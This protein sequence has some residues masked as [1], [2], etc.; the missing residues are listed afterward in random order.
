MNSTHLIYKSPKI[1]IIYDKDND[2]RYVKANKHI[3]EGEIILIEHSIYSKDI[4][5][6]ESLVVNL[7]KYDN[8]L[9]DILYP[10]IRDPND[11]DED[12][13]KKKLELNIMGFKNPDGE[14]SINGKEWTA[15]NHNG[16]NPNVN[17]DCIIVNLP[18]LPLSFMVMVAYK[19]I[20]PNEELCIHY[21]NAYF[22]ESNNQDIY[23]NNKRTQYCFKKN[24]SK[25]ITLIQNYIETQECKDVIRTHIN[26]MNGL[27]FNKKTNTYISTDKFAK[28]LK[29]DLKAEIYYNDI[30]KWLNDTHKNNK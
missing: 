24:K 15:F 30:V 25:I 8:D 13:L 2:N 12:V 1:S 21:G 27:F 18:K 29:G 19:D 6:Y 22:N 20:E 10:R 16:I 14:Y 28:I 5:N 11:E 3:Y 9:Y 7:T 17:F 4:L 26:A 23:N